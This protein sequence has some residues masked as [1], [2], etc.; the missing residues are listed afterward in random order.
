MPL[1]KNDNNELV[2]FYH[3]PKNGGTSIENALK[4]DYQL[5]LYNYDDSYFIGGLSPQ[6][7]EVETLHKI[8]PKCFCSKSFTVVRNPI[9]RIVSEYKYTIERNR[10]IRFLF[11]LN[12]FV[13]FSIDKCKKNPRFQDNHIRPQVDFIDNHTVVY[14]LESDMGN[15]S[16]DLNGLLGFNKADVIKHENKSSV[17]I[18]EKLDPFVISEIVKFY[19]K[20]FEH[21]GYDI[22]NDV[23][24]HRLNKLLRMKLKVKILAYDFISFILSLKESK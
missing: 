18:N 7:L 20:D 24:I 3:I 21:F 23:V 17:K 11:N 13:L 2:V 12:E 10:R 15:L 8:I 22:P 5:Y 14:K 4:Y 19:R 16:K 9:K 1:I 6:H